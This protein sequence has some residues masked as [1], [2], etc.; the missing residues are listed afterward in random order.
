MKLFPFSRSDRLI[1]KG[2]L[3]HIYQFI[4]DIKITS[5][6]HKNLN[7]ATSKRESHRT[8]VLIEKKHTELYMNNLTF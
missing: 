2:L 3:T 8:Q 6:M 1:V 4:Q 5:D 7:V